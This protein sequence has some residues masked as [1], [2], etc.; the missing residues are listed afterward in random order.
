MNQLHYLLLICLISLLSA[1]GFQLRGETSLP[2][3][4]QR[5][6]LTLADPLNPLKRDLEGALQRAG[7]KVESN[8]GEGIVEVKI[9]IISLAPQP[10][11]ITSTTRVRE[12][13]MIYHLALQVDDTDG[14]PVLPLQDIELTRSFTFDETQA[15]G[16][17]AE[18]EEL[19]KQMQRDMVQAIMRRLGAIGKGR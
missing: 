17:A 14:H 1:C 8:S 15:L 3:S 16:I 4:L 11:S 2:L 12:F 5:V 10:Q 19:K 9:P 7:A 6:H 13:V 18:Q